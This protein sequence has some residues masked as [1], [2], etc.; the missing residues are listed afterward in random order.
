MAVTRLGR[1][2]AQDFSTLVGRYALAGTPDQVKAR[3]HE[4]IDAGAS[5]VMLSSACPDDHIDENVRL[6]AEE[7]IPAFR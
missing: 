2:Y 6:I 1:Q 7:V 5:M 4:Y 3:L